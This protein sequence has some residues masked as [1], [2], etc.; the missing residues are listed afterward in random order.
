[1]EAIVLWGR[2]E[3]LLCACLYLLALQSQETL[4]RE[5]EFYTHQEEM[6]DVHKLLASN[7][8]VA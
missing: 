8:K 5:R 6:G 7:F 2:A 3:G 4:R 1:M